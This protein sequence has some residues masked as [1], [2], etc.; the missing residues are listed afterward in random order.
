MTSRVCAPA[1][2]R[3]RDSCCL[4]TWT[5][6]PEFRV[7]AKHRLRSTSAGIESGKSLTMSKACFRRTCRESS[8]KCTTVCRA[9]SHHMHST[10]NCSLSDESDDEAQA[11]RPNTNRSHLS[12]NLYIR[13]VIF[14]STLQVTSAAQPSNWNRWSLSSR[15]RIAMSR[16]TSPSPRLS[17]SLDT[18][19]KSATIASWWWST[20][21]PAPMWTSLAFSS[22]NSMSL[23]SSMLTS[24]L[25]PPT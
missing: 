21:S 16:Q 6:K 7:C 23:N 10:S 19:S 4:R 8:K 15:L 13:R 3:R 12:T 24:S 2:R 17:M 20:L 1:I 25:S 11:G 14:C 18:A 5:S 9:A 22:S